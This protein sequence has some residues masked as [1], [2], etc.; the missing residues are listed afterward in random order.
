MTMKVTTATTM[1]AIV[2]PDKLFP[3]LLDEDGVAVAVVAALVDTE[4]LLVDVI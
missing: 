4:L 3:L 1:P 2:P